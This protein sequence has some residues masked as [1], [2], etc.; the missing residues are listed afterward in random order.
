[1]QLDLE[2][3][4]FSKPASTNHKLHLA[5]MKLHMWPF[6]PLDIS[7][8][9]EPFPVFQAKNRLNLTIPYLYHGIIPLH[10][11]LLNHSELEK[12]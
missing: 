11:F 2:A 1:M 7:L 4:D 6:G 10:D 5:A 8:H 12:P 9:L 3:V